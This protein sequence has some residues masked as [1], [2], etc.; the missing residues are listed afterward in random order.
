MLGYPPPKSPCRLAAYTPAQLCENSI[1][2]YRWQ[3][4]HY[5]KRKAPC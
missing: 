4:G 5:L 2:P 1:E 3:L